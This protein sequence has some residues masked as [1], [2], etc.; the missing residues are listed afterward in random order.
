MPRKS[1][2]ERF[3]Q[4]PIMFVMGLVAGGFSGVGAE[5][6][7]LT[8][9]ST[10][11]MGLTTSRALGSDLRNAGFANINFSKPLEHAGYVRDPVVVAGGLVLI[12]TQAAI[13]LEKNEVKYREG[14]CD[15]Q[16]FDPESEEILRKSE[17]AVKRNLML[18][19]FPEDEKLSKKG[20]RKE[21]NAFND[22]SRMPKLTQEDLDKGVDNCRGATAAQIKSAERFSGGKNADYRGTE[23]T[24]VAGFFN[25]N[26]KDV[27]FKKV[28]H[29]F[30]GG[31][32][33]VLHASKAVIIGHY[34]DQKKLV[35]EIEKALPPSWKAVGVEKTSCAVVGYHLDT[36]LSVLEGIDNQPNK[37]VIF[38]GS[39]HNKVISD[40][41]YAGLVAEFTKENILVLNEEAAN[42]RNANLIQQ[43]AKVLM[44]DP[45]SE[46]KK[47]LENWGYEVYDAQKS[48]A[49][50]TADNGIHCNTLDVVVCDENT[51]E[52]C[53]TKKDPQNPKIG[54]PTCA[55][56]EKEGFPSEKIDSAKAEGIR[57][58]QEQRVAA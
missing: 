40:D 52:D 5:T 55:R 2:Y 20:L 21:I 8:L 1:G 31:D 38:G 29:Y 54:T 32:F 46:V 48:K 53:L 27:V 19:C 41:S 39:A 15:Q 30:E 50:L 9:G 17:N 37:L 28:D 16:P 44:T 49:Y 57:G 58:K 43:G 33:V 11:G 24:I 45:T 25:R 10:F 56:E 13:D 47:A 18:K 42:A 3:T 34:P 7:H 14:Y 36:F 4:S 22:V 12:P 35:S 6:V 51:K 26:F 23:R